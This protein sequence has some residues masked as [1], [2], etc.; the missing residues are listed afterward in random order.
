MEIILLS[1][2]PMICLSL[3]QF[4][5]R[6]RSFSSISFSSLWPN[7]K[8]EAIHSGLGS[9]K[10][11]ISSSLALVLTSVSCEVVT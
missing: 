9:D 4:L 3:V 2:L 10:G 7:H 5:L 6:Q 8:V 11:K 1:L